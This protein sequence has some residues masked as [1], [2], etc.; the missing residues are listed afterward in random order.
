MMRPWPP[1]GLLRHGS[2]KKKIDQEP[3]RKFRIKEIAP[4]VHKQNS[5]T[6]KWI[7]CWNFVGMLYTAILQRGNSCQKLAISGLLSRSENSCLSAALLCVC[8]K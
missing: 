2:K 1:L 3:P 6:K 8:E 4:R 7:E 5:G